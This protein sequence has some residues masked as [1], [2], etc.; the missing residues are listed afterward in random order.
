MVAQV[1]SPAV[2]VARHPEPLHVPHLRYGGDARRG[3]RVEARVRQALAGECGTDGAHDRGSAWGGAADGTLLPEPTAVRSVVSVVRLL[4]STS[5]RV[6]LW[7]IQTH[8]THQT[9]VSLL[10]GSVAVPREFS[11]ADE[12]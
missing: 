4:E 2:L 5:V 1:A 8:G 12:R 3:T 6:V 10:S 7:P 11:R 9:T